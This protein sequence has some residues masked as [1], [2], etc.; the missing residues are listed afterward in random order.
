MYLAEAE[1]RDRTGKDAIRAPRVTDSL[2]GPLRL[3]ETLPRKRAPA[4]GTDSV[5]AIAPVTALLVTLLE[6]ELLERLPA[7]RRA[8][9]REISEQG[10]PF[11]LAL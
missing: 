11:S 6:P 5:R 10:R 1:R 9:R 3:A 8:C 2:L 7:V 4:V